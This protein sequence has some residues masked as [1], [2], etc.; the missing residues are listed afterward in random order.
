MEE[1]GNMSDITLRILKEFQIRKTKKQKEKFR[2]FIAHELAKEGI[3]I[4]EE[5]I[6][7]NVNL[8]I[9]NPETSKLFFTAHYDTCPV[10]PFPN[11][12][13]PNSLIGF[14][15]SQLFMV[16][17]MFLLS[18]F[19]SI[20]LFMLNFDPFSILIIFESLLIF[21]IFWM[22]NGKANKHTANDN[23]SGVITVL[24][25][26][27]NMPE[28]VREQVCFVL[29]DNEEKGMLGS[30][31][32]AKKYKN[33]KDNGIFI[34][35]DCVSDGDHLFFFPSKA[36]KKDEELKKL[37]LDS[38]KTKENKHLNINKGFGVYPSDNMKF[39]KAFGV[40]S[41]KNKKI[42]YYMNRIHTS[43]DII[44]DEKNIDIL[45]D[46]TI[47]FAEKYMKI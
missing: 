40:C 23:T 32:F 35:F 28:Q 6:K 3:D 12:I 47:D 38:F 25:A 39:N 10:L 8:I 4:K 11:F 18:V 20:I 24:K 2:T 1:G 36:I 31:V 33:A 29:F 22:Y 21:I 17:I 19:V 44:F 7:N 27:L 41:L 34:N 30:A 14:I 16:I 45:V 43:R 13:I 46:G 15:L 26:A 9:G 42:F 37:I 5:R